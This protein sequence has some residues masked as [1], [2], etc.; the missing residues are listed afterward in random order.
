MGKW[1]KY[2]KGFQHSWLKD[3]IFEKWI[4]EV[5]SDANKA[6]C[7]L[8]KSELRAHKADL[9]KHSDSV[10]HKQN[11]SK[12][13]SKQS[14]KTMDYFTGDKVTRLELQLS[15]YIA[16]HSSIRSIDHLCD[17]LKK[18]MPC[19]SSSE[20]IR[21][22]RTKCTAII[23]KVLSPVLLKEIVADIKDSAFSLIIDESTDIACIKHLCV[24]VCYYSSLHNKIVSQFL[25][26]IPVTSTTAEA[27]HQHIKDYF[28]EIGVDLN[29]CFAIATDG[30]Q[31]LCG[32]HHSAYMLMK[33]DIPNL[34]LLK[35]TCHS[36]H[37][38]CSHASEEMPSCIDYILR[39]T[40]N[41]FHRS[42]LRREDYMKIY[43]PIHDGKDPLQLI[44]LSGTRW[45]ARSN[46]VKRVLDQWDALKTHFQF[47][48]S[49][50]DKYVSR[51]LYS[52]YSDHKN[53]LY[54][55]FLRP[56]LNDFERINLLFQ[57]EEADHCS[58]LRELEC[59]TLVMLRRVLL[60]NY[61]KLEVDL[62]MS[63]IFLPLKNVD[64]GYEFTS[65]V[66]SK[67]QANLISEQELHD[68]KSRCHK[69]L[70]RACKELLSRL[71][72]NMETLKKIKN[73]SPT[74]CLS[75]TRP[76]FSELPLELADRF[77]IADIEGQ[78]RTLLNLDWNNICDGDIPTSGNQ[79]WTKAIGVTN[80]GGD[81]ILKDISEFAL[82]V[83]SL[84]I[85]NALVERVFSRVTSVKTKLRNR[86]GLDLL[87]SILRIKTSLELNGKCCTGFEPKRSMLNFDSSIYKNEKNEEC[88]VDDLLDIFD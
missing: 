20:N 12:I 26:L 79:F 3:P 72:E 74:V 65:L 27:L 84:P 56:I 57:R 18:D 52:M 44:P 87:T 62:N 36:L 69:F 71:P 5:K 34:I 32:C 21:L 76:P 31:N 6:Y 54:L 59:F 35:C 47:A 24:C 82:K 55:T 49:S 10:K 42:A 14:L 58:L 16:C 17:I 81:F 23:K 15:A 66:S 28:Q 43:K 75:H 67:K 78:W 53:E 86:M 73:L 80:A 30:A 51:E 63:S 46:S 50:C 11:M 33:K 25:G 22:H 1:A 2:N 88:L 64:F 61:V 70:L 37:L 77:E 4:E 39:E 83:Y 8:C 60:S 29:K 68:V 45:L 38:A 48:A 19:S 40:Y 9:K 7:K 85:S 13:S 41:W